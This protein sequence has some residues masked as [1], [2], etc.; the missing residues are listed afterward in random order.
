MQEYSLVLDSPRAEDRG[1]THRQLARSAD[2][3]PA[4]WRR[5]AAAVRRGWAEQLE[6]YERLSIINRPWTHDQLHWVR[7][8]DGGF[9]LHGSIPPPRRSRGP[10]TTGGWC[11]CV[12]A[13]RQ[14][15]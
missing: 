12:A 15:Q 3:G 4:R 9:E 11:P 2:G 13:A 5:W 10:V 14:R 8:D 7:T 6:A 1:M